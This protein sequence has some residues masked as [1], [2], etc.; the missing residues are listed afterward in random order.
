MRQAMS[1]TYKTLRRILPFRE[2]P[3]TSRIN[4]VHSAD[5][6]SL[7][8]SEQVVIWIPDGAMVGHGW[9]V[10]QQAHYATLRSLLRIDHPSGLAKSKA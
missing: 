9:L 5:D 8:R 10:L 6:E 3:V 7:P 1:R 2:F 4:Q